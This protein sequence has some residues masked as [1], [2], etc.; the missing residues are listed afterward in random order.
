[1]RGGVTEGSLGI[2]RGTASL[3]KNTF[4]AGIGSIGKISSSLSAG[5]LAITGDEQF[6]QRRTM[7]MIREKPRGIM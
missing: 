4:S 1:M 2:A 5:M 6:I 7:G 3:F